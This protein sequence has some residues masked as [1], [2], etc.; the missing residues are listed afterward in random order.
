MEERPDPAL[1]VDVSRG[2]PAALRTLY[3][4]HGSRAFNFIVKMTGNRD[5]AQDL[6]Q[7]TFT[8]VWTMAHQY[9]PGRGSFRGW[10]F[11]IAL[12]TT[13]DEMRR[14]S[15]RRHVGVEDADVLPSSADGPEVLARRGQEARR[16]AAALDRLPAHLREVV[17]LKVYQQLKF[18]EIAQVTG[19]PVGTLKAR[20]HRAIAAL[21][22]TLGRERAGGDR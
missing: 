3:E 6:L 4:R 2:D 13:R 16:V 19:A 9:D 11:A 1:V 8:R 22:E 5:L 18:S 14:M 7:E 12:N 20:M 21:R 15:A 10:L 17:V